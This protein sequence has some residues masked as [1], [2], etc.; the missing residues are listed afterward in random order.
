[1][2]RGAR[3]VGKSY[4]VREVGKSFESYVEINFD[5]MPDLKSI[6]ERDLS[7]ERIIRDLGISVG[8][9]IIPG[10]TLLFFDEIQECPN[11]VKSI[12]YF[13]EKLPRLHLVTAGSLLDFILEEIGVPVGRIEP[14]YLYPMSFMEFLSATGNQ[15]LR[16]EVDNHELERIMPEVIHNKLISLVG[17]YMAI[18]GMP[19]AVKEWIENGDPGKCKKVHYQII[20]TFQQDFLKYTRRNK[21]KYVDMVFNSIP[22]L[23]G[24]KF[25]FSTVNPDARSRELRPALELLSKAGVAHIIYHS[26]S[27]GVPLGAEINLQRFKVIF[28][29]IA[30]AQAVLGSDSATWIVNAKLQIVNQGQLA[31]AFIGQELLAYSPSYRKSSL[32]YWAREKRGSLSE[33]DYVTAYKGK[34]VPVE[35]KAGQTGGL[36]S[37]QIFLNE[38][39]QSDSGIHFSLNN[40][41][42]TPRITHLPLYAISSYL[43]I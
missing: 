1:M 18:G 40:Y 11:A 32:Y 6:F 8:E 19:E 24:N 22:R 14:L 2:L 23:I 29:D 30:L 27:N 36:K 39:K 26:S 25:V 4:L 43:S 15:M 35:V 20:D 5:E 3:Q 13:Y 10:K 16:E 34:V 21:L 17:E 7:P 33:V 31:E 9:T 12:R 42:K 38:K 41:R 28:M 37:M